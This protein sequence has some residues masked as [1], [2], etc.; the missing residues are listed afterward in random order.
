[1]GEDVVVDFYYELDSRYSYLASTQIEKIEKEVNCRFA[2][3]PVKRG[4]LPSLRGATPFKGEPLSGQYVNSWRLQDAQTWADY[5]GVPY[6]DF[7]KHRPELVSLPAVAAGAATILGKGVP[8]SRL[9][10]KAFFVDGTIVDRNVCIAVAK[11]CGIPGDQ[12]ADK[13][14]APEAESLVDTYAK[15]AHL[16]GAF[17]VPS[18][19]IGDQMIFGNDRLVL[20][21]HLILK[22][23][24]AV[25]RLP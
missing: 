11:Q 9:L 3:K 23:R 15:E 25:E 22:A 24:K 14:D 2:W 5:Y 13:L 17:G 21:K 7:G 12:Y 18:F 4:S 16:Q 8:F 19:A 20:V 1:M 6:N 10:F